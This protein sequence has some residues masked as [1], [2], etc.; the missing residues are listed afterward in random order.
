MQNLVYIEVQKMQKRKNAIKVSGS[1]GNYVVDSTSTTTEFESVEEIT[2][3]GYN[4]HVNGLAEGTYYLVETQAPAGY[5][6]LTAPIEIKS[7]R[8]QIQM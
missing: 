5:N 6:K 1:N 8:A 7:Q 2:G 4:L 3:A